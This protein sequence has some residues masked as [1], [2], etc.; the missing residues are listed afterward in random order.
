MRGLD[1]VKKLIAEAPDNV[2]VTD[3]EM[4]KPRPGQVLVRVVRSLISPGSEL[5]RVR[6]L[7]GDADSKWPNHDLGYAAAGE[8]VEL[9]QGVE[10]FAVGDRVA[11]AEHHQEYVV[12][13]SDPAHPARETV[14]LPDA[15]GWDAAPFVI[16]GRSCYNWTRTAD[17]QI[18][19]T[20]A[21]MGLGL[22]GLLMA[23]WA[24]VRGPGQVIGIDLFPKRLEL[25]GR[26]GVDHAISAAETDSVE[27]VRELTGGVGA[28]VTIHCVSGAAVKSFEASQQMTRAGGRVVLLGIHSE[29]LTIL[30]HEF[31]GKQ[32]IGGG[33]GYKMEGGYLRVGADLIA[34]GRL[35]VLDIVTHSV[36]FIEAPGIYDML[37]HR[38]GEAGAVILRWADA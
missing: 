36:R 16:W 31:L 30:R 28:D 6:R 11:A 26:I 12:S 35:P 10:G 21:I 19:D 33:V 24:R 8:I 2:V 3:V 38:P 37:N 4:P 9:G 18:G 27:A 13:P 7:P 5:N 15:I 32:L 17:I 34:R 23:M 25:A 29:P 14:P 1:A 22:V 20:V